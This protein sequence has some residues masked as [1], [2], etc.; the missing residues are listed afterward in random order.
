MTDYWIVAPDKATLIAALP[1]WAKDTDGN[2]LDFSHTHA[3]L[4]DIPV[5]DESG[6]HAL[7]RLMDDSLRDD[8]ETQL[9]AYLV[10]TPSMPWVEFA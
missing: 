6:C 7:L 2:I 3:L 10:P 8:V 9:A 5:A 1:A 4:V